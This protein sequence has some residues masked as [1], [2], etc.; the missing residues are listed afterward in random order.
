MSSKKEAKPDKSLKVKKILPK[1]EKA[2]TPKFYSVDGD[3]IETYDIEIQCDPSGGAEKTVTP[4][5][6]YNATLE[7]DVL[8]NFDFVS[9][10]A[11][12][13]PSNSKASQLLRNLY[14]RKTENAVVYESKE[15]SEESVSAHQ[16]PQHHIS[17]SL[18]I[19]KNPSALSAT[20]KSA[21]FSPQSSPI[22]STQPFDRS[23]ESI[24]PDDELSL[25]SLSRILDGDQTEAT[26]PV[27]D[28]NSTIMHYSDETPVKPTCGLV[29]LW[30]S[31]FTRS[32]KT[33]SH[34]DNDHDDVGT[35]VSTVQSGDENSDASSLR[36]QPRQLRL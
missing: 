35:L 36:R 29:D 14:N 13:D 28:G 31:L 32:S 27:K 8:E 12:Q 19:R 4:V 5:Y 26:R 10:V 22:R 33:S 3:I 34:G 7:R 17:E 25:S 2:E 20:T 15:E 1:M 24:I 30:T 16:Q 9:F 6:S 21:Q 18:K 23:I 11:E